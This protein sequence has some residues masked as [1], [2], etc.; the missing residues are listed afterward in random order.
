MIKTNALR[1]HHSCYYPFDS[2]SKAALGVCDRCVY[3]SA[4]LKLLLSWRTR[5]VRFPLG[6]GVY[7]LYS[8]VTRASALSF[9]EAG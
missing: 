5:A 6:G 4:E 3:L 1:F 2:K 8:V 9:Q 7:L